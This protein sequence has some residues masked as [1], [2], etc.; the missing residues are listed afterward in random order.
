MKGIES[1]EGKNLSNFLDETKVNL[2][3]LVQEGRGLGGRKEFLQDPLSSI[4][5]LVW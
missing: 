2:Q 4:F 5:S 3:K 1:F